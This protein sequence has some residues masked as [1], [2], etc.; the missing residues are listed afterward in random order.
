MVGNMFKSLADIPFEVTRA[1][2]SHPANFPPP[3]YAVS[4]SVRDASHIALGA[5]TGLS[6]DVGRIL[7]A[8]F[9][10]P[11]KV[12]LAAPRGFHHLPLLHG[13]QSVRKPERITGVVSGLQ[14][15]AK[16]PTPSFS[17]PRFFSP[18][19][20][21]SSADRT[22]EITYSVS[23]GVAGLLTHLRDG[24]R[25]D[26]AVGL[27]KGMGKGLGVVVVKPLAGMGGFYRAFPRVIF[28]RIADDGRG[29]GVVCAGVYL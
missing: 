24:A 1:L 15:V 22:E 25:R 29:S 14:A 6:K 13:D 2:H 12:T 21:A 23:D 16:V 3:K 7:L 18:L 9:R 17:F 4:T 8:G 5:V 19:R 27:S 28:V 20:P 11:F 10:S 26:G